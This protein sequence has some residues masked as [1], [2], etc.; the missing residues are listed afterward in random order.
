MGYDYRQATRKSEERVEGDL[1]FNN[2]I[3]VTERRHHQLAMVLRTCTDIKDNGTEMGNTKAVLYVRKLPRC[4]S[5][6]WTAEAPSHITPRKPRG[7]EIVNAFRPC[8]VE[9]SSEK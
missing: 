5:K 9:N 8:C 6:E 4:V 7:V 3:Q 1:H 2:A